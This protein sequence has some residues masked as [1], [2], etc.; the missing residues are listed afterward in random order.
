MT[1]EEMHYDFK[2][3]L[4]K[5][6]SRQRRNFFVPEIDWLLNEAQE[7]FVKMV[8]MP[9]WG[10]QPMGFE[11]TQR[12]MDDVRV[13]VKEGVVEPKV[14]T[15]HGSYSYSAATLPGDY[16]H[17]VRGIVIAKRR[18]CDQ[19]LS[20]TLRIR[21]H[22]DLNHVSPFDRSDVLWREVNGL[23]RG[24]ELLLEK[25]TGSPV[26]VTYPSV[27]LTYLRKPTYMHFASGHGKGAYSMPSGAS[28]TGKRDC[29]LP[30][31]THREIVDIAVMQAASQIMEAKDMQ[32]HVA[33]LGMNQLMEE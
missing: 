27:V 9:R 29:E 8:A 23:F 11:R 3:K 10:K 4:N 20:C 21:Q 31:H 15:T 6:D 32:M 28:L 30:E 2:M 18:G 24:S 14:D 7:L 5:L 19:E 25:P 1:I 26:D 13:L 12:S 22:D 33:K 16:W 17:F